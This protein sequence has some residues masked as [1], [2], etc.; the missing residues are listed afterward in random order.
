MP[1]PVSTNWKNAIQAQ[2]RYPA[3]MRMDIDVTPPGLRAGAKAVVSSQVEQATAQQTVDGFRKDITPYATFEDRWWP[4]DGSHCLLSRDA[5]LNSPPGWWSK[6]VNTESSTLTFTFDQPYDI[7][8]ISIVWDEVNGDT[9]TSV[10]IVGYSEGDTVVA[11]YTETDVTNFMNTPLEGAKKVV[12]TVIGWSNPST[13]MRIAEVTFGLKMVFSNDQINSSKLSSSADL[14]SGELPTLE[15][16][17]AINN[18]DRS[19]DPTL[20][21]GYAGYLAQR[22]L[23]NIQWGFETI[24]GN[25]EWLDPWPI[26]LSSWSIPSDSQVVDLVTTSRLSF[27]DKNYSKGVYT[28]QPVSMLDLALEVLNS[29][30]IIRNTSDEEPWE[31]DPILSTIKTRAPMP[32]DATNAL[33]QLIANASGCI[34]DID[35]AN[36]WIRIRKTCDS[37]DYT[38]GTMQQMGDPAFS[39]I[40]R[41]KSV[42]V[43]MRTFSQQSERKQVYSFQ[44]RLGSTTTLEVMYDSDAIVVNPSTSVQ[45]ATLTGAIYYARGAVLTIVPPVSGADVSISIT[46]YVVDESTTWI[47]TYYDSSVSSGL[48]ITVD[49]PLITETETVKIV[50]DAV[51]NMYLRQVSAT[52]PYLGYPELCT[53]DTVKLN[54]N[55]GW[56]QGDISKVSLD[57]NGGFDGS[58]KV[59]MLN[60]G[61]LGGYDKSAWF[62]DEIM[63]GEV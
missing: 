4:G 26:Y 49:N 45:G 59:K 38:I 46:G 16:S 17:L 14:L 42:V 58:L 11:Q 43:G 6:N 13:R 53:G 23:V 40:D 27:L 48:E 1:I 8:G 21:T 28:G 63:C 44:G 47:Q 35:P 18:Y 5:E 31:L 61:S 41:L 7:P 12:I 33:I 39:I 54:T 24:Y 51:K 60:V 19:F 25:I 62:S 57:F 20:K 50:S 30:N 15:V 9:P 37:A 2:F 22:Q 34:L 56:F 52:V 32:I 3:Y 29:S 55:Y 36:N 10:S